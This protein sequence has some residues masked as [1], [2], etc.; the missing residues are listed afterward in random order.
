MGMNK[1]I[2]QLFQQFVDK[3]I[4]KQEWERFSI[5]LLDLENDPHLLRLLNE[6]WDYMEITVGAEIE[7]LLWKLSLPGRLNYSI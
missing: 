6:L 2:N 1:E 7:H 4:D 3:N 5:C